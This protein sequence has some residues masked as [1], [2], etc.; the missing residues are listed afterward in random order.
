MKNWLASPDKSS[1]FRWIGCW[2]AVYAPIVEMKAER[3][4]ERSRTRRGTKKRGKGSSLRK[5][6]KR[7]VARVARDE[8]LNSL[9]RKMEKSM[10]AVERIDKLQMRSLKFGLR[11]SL[12]R[13]RTERKFNEARDQLVDSRR[14]ERDP[15]HRPLPPRISEILSG[16]VRNLRP[17]LAAQRSR[18]IDLFSGVWGIP[19]DAA[20]KRL[21]MIGKHPAIRALPRRTLS[22]WATLDGE[23]GALA[24]QRL[25]QI[26]QAQ[27]AG[28]E[29]LPCPCARCRL[30]SLCPLGHGLL[31]GFRTCGHCDYE[32]HERLPFRRN[33]RNRRGERNHPRRGNSSSYPTERKR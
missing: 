15:A 12:R 25:A 21:S 7:A 11:L 18:E 14:S 24:R 13:I 23:P 29:R 19:R 10:R 28:F 16:V 6:L 27:I 30:N 5:S 4:V 33:G 17:K 9:P 26:R 1:P 8:Y 22:E 31:A 32:R 20:V 3:G 2:C